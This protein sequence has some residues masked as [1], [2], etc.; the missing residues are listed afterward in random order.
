MNKQAKQ[1]KKFAQQARGSRERFFVFYYYYVNY[2]VIVTFSFTFYGRNVFRLRY[3]PVAGVKRTRL[4]FKDPGR[5]F[6]VPY[7]VARRAVNRHWEVWG[8][9]LCCDE[10]D[11]R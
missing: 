7:Y 5:H 10:G 9:L 11:S 3:V 2:Y 8:R 6:P 4:A 1:Q